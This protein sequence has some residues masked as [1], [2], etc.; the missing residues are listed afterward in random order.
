MPR[1]GENIRK[2]KDGRWEA[3]YEKSRD[4]NGRIQYGYVYAHTYDSVKKKKLA[5]LCKNRP[6]TN[7]GRKILFRN[8]N[9]EWL[10]SVRY[11]VKISTYTCYETLISIHII[12]EF[13]DIPVKY[14]SSDSIYRFSE[15]L[16]KEGLSSRTIKNILI[17][18]H[19]IL[20][21]GE[22]QGYINHLSQLE[23]RYPKII[24]HSF[25]IISQE[26]LTKLIS[27]L[28][29]DT[30]RFSIGILLCIYTGIRVGELSGI[31]WEDIDFEQRIL[32]IR[33]TI[34]RVKNLDHTAGAD[35]LQKTILLIGPP[36]S[37]SSIRDIPISDFL[38]EKL[39]SIAT[40]QDAYLL[41][42]TN[43]KCM[44]P[45]TIQR[46]FKRLLEQ[47]E[48][49]NINI[50]SLRHAFASRCIE[51]GIDSKTLSEILGHSSVKITMDIYVHCSMKQKQK[52]M[53]KLYY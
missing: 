6:Q 45:R 2:R 7:I 52:Y 51:M 20:Q 15:K 49:P 8:L 53:E 28:C 33:R 31:R 26:N 36:K 16:K 27:V 21:Y 9:Q 38:L 30:S 25:N 44:E 41:T 37:P 29:T 22:K 50:H 14:I 10:A 19:S 35:K 43:L 39:K 23:F 18:F 46:K 24:E 34:S 11:T 32:H 48:I 3:R 5:I 13:G 1:K 17:L 42:G 40:D 4:Q 47:C 12:P